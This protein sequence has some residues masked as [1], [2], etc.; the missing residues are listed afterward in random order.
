MSVN[1][2]HRL[3]P[4]QTVSDGEVCLR[5]FHWDIVNILIIN[6]DKLLQ[7]GRILDFQNADTKAFNHYLTA[8]RSGFCLSGYRFYAGLEAVSLSNNYLTYALICGGVDNPSLRS[9]IFTIAKAHVEGTPTVI[10]SS[11]GGDGNSNSDL[12]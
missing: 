2:F 11:D 10:S 3:R 8:L 5:K 1:S 9:K 7:R 4:S 6:T 12:R